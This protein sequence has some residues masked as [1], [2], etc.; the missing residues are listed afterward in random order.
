MPKK[1]IKRHGARVERTL[2]IDP[3]VMNRAGWAVCTLTF[4]AQGKIVSDEWDFGSFEIC[5][6]NFEMRC[7]DLT[8]WI[9]SLH[10]DFEYLVCEWPTYYHSAKGQI[11]AQQG[12][13]INLAGIAMYVAGYF[14]VDFRNLFLY[15]APNW[16]GTVQKAVT[17]K[18]F[19][20][21]FQMND[22]H[23]D[24]DTVDACMMLVWH[25]RAQGYQV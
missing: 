11:A 8:D 14:R 18:R 6:N 24:H 16:K 2:A 19:F 17:Q 20:K 7:S 3:S 9:K 13:T 23:V 12:Y 15:T 1:I 10:Y 21:M 4:N 25:L 22:L 5:G